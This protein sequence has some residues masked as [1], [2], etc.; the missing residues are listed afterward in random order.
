MG[1]LNEHPWTL[2]IVSCYMILRM[3][4]FSNQSCRENQ[5]TYFVLYNIF[6]KNR[7]VYEI[8]W[9]YLVEPDR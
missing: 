8:N 6:L 2:M 7:A 4:N 9:N 1:T 5:S 3:R